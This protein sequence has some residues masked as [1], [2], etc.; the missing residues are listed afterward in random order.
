MRWI[1]FLQVEKIG[2]VISQRP[3][4]NLFHILNPHNPFGAVMKR[5]HSRRRVDDFQ[6][7]IDASDQMKKLLDGMAREISAADYLSI[8][9]FL[10]ALAAEARQRIEVRSRPAEPLAKE[11]E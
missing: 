6:A 4:G 8:Q 3:I 5:V 1:M 10:D 2:Q 11:S 7:M 9:K